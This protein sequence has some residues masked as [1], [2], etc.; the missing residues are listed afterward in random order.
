MKKPL[1][2]VLN[3][4]GIGDIDLKTEKET[5]AFEKK[6][7]VMIA[8]AEDEKNGGMSFDTFLKIGEL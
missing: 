6:L 3:A 4:L 2:Q 5:K 7:D 8:E 1:N